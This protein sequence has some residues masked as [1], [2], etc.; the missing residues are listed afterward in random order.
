VFVSVDFFEGILL[1]FLGA[2]QCIQCT[3]GELSTEQRLLVEGTYHRS[4]VVLVVIVGLLAVLQVIS[5]MAHA[6]V[7]RLEEAQSPEVEPAET[8]LG[9]LRYTV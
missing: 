2:I 9:P 1:L 6:A 4:P 3:V 7:L 5:S 8:F